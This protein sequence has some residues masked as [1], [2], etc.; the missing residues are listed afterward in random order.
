[1]TETERCIES[2]LAV[3]QRYA[4]RDRD[5]CKLS[6]KEFLEFMNT[7]L[8]AFTKNQQPGVLDRM[9]KKLDLNSDGQ[10]DFQEFLNLIGG[11]AVACHESLVVNSPHP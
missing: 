3:F 8:A 1:P 7:E 5:N 2:L 9:M 10:L 11:I 6:K 4:G